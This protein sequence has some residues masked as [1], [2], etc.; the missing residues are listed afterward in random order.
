VFTP[1]QTGLGER[2]HLMSAHIEMETFVLDILNVLEFED[3]ADVVLVGHSYGAR[4]VSGVVDRVPSKIRRL[5]YIDGGLALSG[6]SRLDS[7]PPEAREKRIESSMKFDGG[8]SVPPP[9]ATAFGIVHPETIRWVD[10]LMT[11]QPLNAE[12]TKVKLDNP[13]GNG[14]PV[15]YVR[16]VAPPFPT[17]EP[18]AAYAKQ[19]SDWRYLELNAGHGAIVTHPEQIAKILMDESR[20]C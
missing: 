5:I 16:C 8:V 6:G 13:L 4:T 11:P 15:T 9:S 14:R 12:R 17:V 20:A 19:R 1:T 3:L 10:R 18:S 7:M 2:R